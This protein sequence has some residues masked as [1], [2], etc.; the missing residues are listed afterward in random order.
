MQ[1]RCSGRKLEK[2]LHEVWLR[3]TP[4]EGN[5]RFADV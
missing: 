3:R 5:G 4:S 2:S 1:S